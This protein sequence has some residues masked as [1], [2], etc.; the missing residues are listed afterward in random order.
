MFL[1][2]TSEWTADQIE[3]AFNIC[4]ERN[5]IPPI[6][7]QAHYNFMNREIIDTNYRDLFRFRKYGSELKVK[8]AGKTRLEGKDYLMQDGDI[9]H[10]RFNV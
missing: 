1:L 6:C 8:E 3:R 2:A 4:K 7:D 10:F 9:C 5:L